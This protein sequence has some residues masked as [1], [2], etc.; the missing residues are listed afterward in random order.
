MP[1]LVTPDLQDSPVRHISCPQFA[2][3][4]ESGE[5]CLEAHVSPNVVEL[6][7]AEA[8]APSY[9]TSMVWCAG[10]IWGVCGVL[11]TG[12]GG[13]GSGRASGVEQGAAEDAF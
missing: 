4:E 2:Q 7:V 6:P 13:L 10:C 12:S 9:F 3:I 1:W 8:W 5:R 11:M